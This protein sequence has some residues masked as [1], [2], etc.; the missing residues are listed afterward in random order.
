M[1]T[2][3]EPNSTSSLLLQAAINDSKRLVPLPDSSGYLEKQ[4][5]TDDYI[6]AS[7]HRIDLNYPLSFE[8]SSHP[9]YCLLLLYSER[10]LHIKFE[11][12]FQKQLW[13]HHL[14]ANREEE[15]PH[16]QSGWSDCPCVY[17]IHCFSIAL[18]VWYGDAASYF[19]FLGEPNPTPFHDQLQC[20]LCRNSVPKFSCLVWAFWTT[21]LS[22]L[23]L[24]GMVTALS[25][26]F[27]SLVQRPGFQVLQI[28]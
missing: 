26:Q 13:W 19:P 2:S 14:A 3:N 12:A 7:R 5:F 24:S 11:Y 23:F 8:S 17:F 16:S 6:C 1:T 10:L 20:H 25:K 21:C 18:L 15:T 27:L 22:L 28:P 9:L 4:T